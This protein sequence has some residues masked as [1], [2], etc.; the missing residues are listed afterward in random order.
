MKIYESSFIRIDSVYIDV[1]KSKNET[2]FSLQG[3]TNN[4]ANGTVIYMKNNL[5]DKI[6]DST[7]VIN[8]HFAFFTPLED[9]PL[10]VLLSTKDFTQWRDVWIENN[11]MFFDATESNFKDARITGSKSEDLI[12]KLY[13]NTST[14]SFEERNELEKIFVTKNPNSIVSAFILS[15]F[16]RDWGLEFTKD[17]FDKFPQKI[18]KSEYGRRI[19]NFIASRKDIKIGSNFAD[20]QIKDKNGIAVKLSDLHSEITLLE[21]W[22]SWCAPC[23]KENPNLVKIYEEYKSKGFEIVSISLDKEEKKWISA[24]QKDGLLWPNFCDFMAWESESSLI[25]GVYEIPNN[26]LINKKGEIIAK[27]IHGEELNKKLLELMK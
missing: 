14:I 3:S 24:I 5:S 10:R 4:V 26:F 6:I 11:K 13:K 22:A 16:A 15:V 25:Y 9:F 2:T 1:Y 18:K 23:R 12:Q 8:N 19:S 21:F 27:N 7:S 17:N 20:F